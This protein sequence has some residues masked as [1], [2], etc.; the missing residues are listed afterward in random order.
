[1]GNWLRK[2][3]K[4]L[5]AL[6][7]AIMVVN[8]FTPFKGK[9][10]RAEEDDKY[11]PISDVITSIDLD[12][13]GESLNYTN[14]VGAILRFN[15]PTKES[16]KFNKDHCVFVF[17]FNK[18]YGQMLDK[19]GNPTGDTLTD[20]LNKVN[21]P[22][23]SDSPIDYESK[24]GLTYTY[25]MIDGVLYMDFSNAF[26]D[27]GTC[28]EEELYGHE[29]TYS[30]SLGFDASKLD[31]NE[32]KYKIFFSATV[33]SPKVNPTITVG[34]KDKLP[35]PLNISKTAMEIDTKNGVAKYSI[36]IKNTD[37]TNSVDSFILMDQPL[38]GQKFDTSSIKPAGAVT[39][40]SVDENS[41]IYSFSVPSIPAGGEI[42]FTYDCKL[43]DNY[44]S[45]LYAGNVS[46]NV[47]AKPDDPNENRKLVITNDNQDTVNASFG[48]SNYNMILKDGEFQK[49]TGV[50][51]WTIKVNYGDLKYNLDGF[52]LKDVMNNA[53]GE[54]PQDCS[55]VKIV[56]NGDTAN[57]TT[58]SYSDLVSGYSLSG[59]NSY[60][61]T[62]TSTLKE[63]Y[64]T[65]SGVKKENNTATVYDANN[66][67]VA[68][69]EKGI[70]VNDLGLSKIAIKSDMEVVPED[71]KDY[72]IIPYLIEIVVP[73]EVNTDIVVSDTPN[74]MVFASKA[75][76]VKIS[77][78]DTDVTNTISYT[79]ENKT[80]NI[81][82]PKDYANA[83]LSEKTVSIKVYVKESLEYYT[84][85]N[86]NYVSN[87]AK[88]SVNGDEASVTA[89]DNLIPKN[90]SDDGVTRYANKL[91]A[92]VENYNYIYA[93]A[94]GTE[95]NHD[96]Y[97]STYNPETHRMTWMIRINDVGGYSVDKYNGGY[98][99]ISDPV[100]TVKEWED[101]TITD[102]LGGMT[103][104]G[105][106]TPN[107]LKGGILVRVQS[108][109]FYIPS[110]SINTS[111][112]KISFNL[113]DAVNI[114]NSYEK[115]NLAAIGTNPI[116]LIYETVV[117]DS[118][119]PTT[120]EHP[121]IAN[122]IHF[123][124][125][126]KGEAPV[127]SDSTASQL[128]N[129]D[130]LSKTLNT[131]QSTQSTPMQDRATLEYSI[132]INPFAA[133]LCPG[134]SIVVVD[135]LPDVLDYL[136]GSIEVVAYT[137]DGTKEL[138]LDTKIDESVTDSQYE[139]KLDGKNMIIC[140]PDNLHVV[141]T[142][143]TRINTT[144]GN[145]QDI[146][147]INKVGVPDLGNTINSTSE[148]KRHI[149]VNQA[150]VSNDTGFYIDKVASNNP[151]LF[152]K[153]AK[154]RLTEYE[155]DGTPTKKVFEG[156]TPTSGSVRAYLFDEVSG[157]GTSADHPKKN[158]IYKVEE[159]TSPVGYIC[160]KDDVRYVV[161]LDYSTDHK[162]ENVTMNKDEKG[163]TIKVDIVP[164]GHHLTFVNEAI[165]DNP[166][167][168][169]LSVHKIFTGL[170]TVTDEITFVLHPGSK[171]AQGV[172]LECV[173]VEGQIYEYKDTL[174]PGT[175]YLEEKE[176]TSPAG[177]SPITDMVELVVD[178]EGTISINGTAPNGV[179]VNATLSDSETKTYCFDITNTKQGNDKVSATINKMDIAKSE[180]V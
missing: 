130:V 64:D 134:S 39:Y 32:A 167:T 82:I 148:E 44:L 53:E 143:K 38:N 160:N 88:Y 8:V 19:D 49:E 14:N 110:Q 47:F 161:V 77:G 172:E 33:D 93:L 20:M 97:N 165:V 12:S 103:L 158:M 61:I 85:G 118:M 58:I 91:P 149:F 56:I 37:S 60:E 115:I 24:H 27:D 112:S 164:D 35:S 101:I 99:K 55:D 175:Y 34:A 25:D 139:F 62:Y 168:N 2:C 114:Y 43:P 100:L 6:I 141:I 16:G 28:K 81:T 121:A 152:L 96:E 146:T 75:V 71:N 80:L 138:T 46:N 119:M 73:K 108:G 78:T 76:E 92:M 54:V 106:D 145:N 41:N 52:T 127:E 155:L 125:T 174:L 150:T 179:S 9:L 65:N 104:Y 69:G 17:D 3:R 59:T 4:P 132:D 7:V 90:P 98:V 144:S 157:N 23:V 68:I 166:V 95:S 180:E 162:V 111:G 50:T 30:F 170:T 176:Y 131:P 171:T 10:A 36:K 177:Y 15:I 135:S 136:P 45:S 128:I 102:D 122:S 156:T 153:D 83:N 137:K 84:Q 5:A 13:Y 109:D 22:N 126:P 21:F 89:N 26:N 18:V 173:D 42:E 87:S 159:I 1:M 124:G 178:K 113:S 70:T 105:F 29:A 120:N 169:K 133:S 129:Q 140:V 79:N 142:Y 31:N 154:F 72:L 66:N 63:T 51:S 11:I 123:E 40:K 94:N 74:N 117:P 147:I 107:N 116:T 48:N 163:N 151:N 67:A 86:D 57:A